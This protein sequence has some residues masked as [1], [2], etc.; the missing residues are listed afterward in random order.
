[1]V[2]FFQIGIASFIGT[3]LLILAFSAQ[4]LVLWA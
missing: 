4:G 1:M 3:G 2:R